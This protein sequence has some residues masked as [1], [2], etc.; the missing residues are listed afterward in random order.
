MNERAMYSVKNNYWQNK[1]QRAYGSIDNI[2]F[3]H[4]VRMDVAAVL[5]YIKS[6]II[7]IVPK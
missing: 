7:C 4:S 6:V 1:S 3:L 2:Y 5:V